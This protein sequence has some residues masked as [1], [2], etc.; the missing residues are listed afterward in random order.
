MRLAVN[1]SG[2]I[3]WFWMIGISPICAAA[4][5]ATHVSARTQTKIEA[6]KVIIDTDIGTDIDDAFAIEL[7]LRSP[8]LEIL[9]F[10]TTSDDAAARAN[11]IDRMLSE[12]GNT[13]IPVSQGVEPGTSDTDPFSTGTL[14]A[15]RRYGERSRSPTVHPLAVDFILDQ[16]RRFPGQVTLIAVGPLSN[17]GAAIDKDLATFRKLKRVVLKGGWFG[18]LQ[19]PSLGVTGPLAEYNVARDVRSAHKVFQS[20]VP[21]F[22]M[23]MD[24]TAYLALDEVKRRQLFSRGAP[25]TDSLGLLYLLWG[26]TTPVL[27]DAMAVAYVL[28]PNLCPVT[29]MHIEVDSDG[30]T[31]AGTGA[32]N[33][34]VCLH[35]N[36]RQFLDYYVRRLVTDRNSTASAE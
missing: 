5:T 4:A 17:L 8:E 26:E 24:S 27:Y 20:G 36:A 33:A 35:S 13:T 18:P 7:A 16:I 22:L 32:A 6:T 2:S 29:A 23:P 14:G 28:D 9:G 10:S 19:E 30:M 21:I 12:L 1:F 15:Q 11:I 34:Q 25:A 3:L 31:R